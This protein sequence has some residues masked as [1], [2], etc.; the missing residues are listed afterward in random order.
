MA[1]LIGNLLP[2]KNLDMLSSSHRSDMAKKQAFPENWFISQFPTRVARMR[3]L[4]DFFLIKLV[5]FRVFGTPDL[6]TVAMG[7]NGTF[8]NRYSVPSKMASVASL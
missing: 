5:T 4:R 8:I 1:L 6:A 3:L 2:W 7:D